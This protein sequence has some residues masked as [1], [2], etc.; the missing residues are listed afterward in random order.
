MLYPALEDELRDSDGENKKTD[1]CSSGP[2]C[3]SRD[4]APGL[5]QNSER[6]EYLSQGVLHFSGG[7]V[8]KLLARVPLH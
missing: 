1:C 8:K 7:S 4:G 2:G 6:R 5:S 3:H